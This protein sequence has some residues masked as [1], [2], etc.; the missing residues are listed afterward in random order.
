M[1][2]GL[3]R[4]ALVL[5]LLWALVNAAAAQTALTP[6]RPHLPPLAEETLRAQVE[7]GAPLSG[8]GDLGNRG[9]LDGDALP[10]PPPGMTLPDSVP[11]RG[12]ARTPAPAGS[13]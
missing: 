5:A 8:L 10:P 9:D 1:A 2:L 7:D 12:T 4:R 6:R 11:R 13:S 3:T